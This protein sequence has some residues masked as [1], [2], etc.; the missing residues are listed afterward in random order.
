MT[1]PLMPGLQ[2]PAPKTYR[3]GTHRLIAPEETVARVRPFMPAM[4]I[5]R[6]ANITG[7][8][9]IGI[10]V[11]V[12]YRPNARALAVSQGKGLDL[13]AAKASGLME[14]IESYHAERITLPLKRGSYEELRETH[15]LVDVSRLPRARNSI[16][17]PHLALLWVEGYDLLQR[18]RV[19]VPYEMVSLDFTLPLPAGSGCFAANSNGL[20]SG[21]H[22]LEAISHGICEVVERDATTLGALL[23]QEQQDRTRVDL[24]SVDDPGCREALEKF[25]RAGV[26][27]RV[28]DITSDV[29]MP[30]FRCTIVDRS[31]DPLRM[32]YAAGGMGCHPTREVALLRAL[33][34]AAQS[35]L[36]VIS[37]SRDDLFRVDYEHYRSPDIL[38]RARAVMET[39]GPLRRFQDTPAFEADTLDA[40]VSWELERLRAVGITEVIVVDLTRPEFGLPVVKVI[41]PGLEGIMP[42]MQPGEFVPGERARALVRPRV[43][44]KA[45]LVPASE[46]G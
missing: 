4:G 31:E 44:F 13:A 15:R 18:E 35:R 11:V 5:T 6:V 42:D 36:T 34:E 25:E 26:A 45:R 21:N 17:R 10:P 41:I 8:D 32:L 7:L 14:E 2:G 12:V 23:S 27:V 30:A 43:R 40:D 9:C 24:D 3:D 20:A 19:W 29:G 28:W 33:T 37:G 46:A 22:L 16:F 39:T 38:R 1:I